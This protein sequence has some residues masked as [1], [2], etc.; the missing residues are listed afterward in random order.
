[1]ALTSSPAKPGRIGAAFAG[2]RALIRVAYRDPE[3]IPER[4]TLYAS[5][6]LAQPSGDWAADV[7]KARP[8]STRPAIADEVQTQSAKLA[9]IDGAVA[10]TPFFI[11]LVPGYVNYLWQE[12][13]MVLRIAAL[14]GHDPG[15]PRTAAETLVLRGVHPDV[16]AAEAALS[17]VRQRP[18]P[19][20]PSERRPLRHWVRSAYM[21]LVFGGFLSA[22]EGAP[23]HGARAWLRT[24]AG[25]VIGGVIWAI[26]WIVPVTF[27]VAM[28]WGCESHARN[29]GRRTHAFYGGEAATAAAAIDIADARHDRGH[30][31]RQ[32]VRSALLVVSIALPF[33]FIAYANSVRQSTGVNW[34]G[35]LGALVALAVVIA[36]VVA[37][38]RR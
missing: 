32:L 4:L 35:A 21:V 12:Q 16:E 18:L 36:T 34:V 15:D 30:D 27:M 8:D 33:G 25:L 3:H 17:K 31:R 5:A 22:P 13:R 26:T 37:G 29:L 24:A 11:A 6:H 1:M 14:Y 10:G 23:K 2:S 38:S 7:R 20:K 9:R 28:S 19:D